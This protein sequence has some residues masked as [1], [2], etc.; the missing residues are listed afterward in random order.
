[1]NLRQFT[2]EC[3]IPKIFKHQT[4]IKKLQLIYTQHFFNLH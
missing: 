4:L 3:P 1:M 2:E